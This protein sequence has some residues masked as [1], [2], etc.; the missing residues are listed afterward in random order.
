MG[1]K[2]QR[3]T[4]ERISRLSGARGLIGPG[5]SGVP[6]LID[7]KDGKITRIRPLHYE[8]SYDK[9]DFNA[10]KIEARGKDLRA[11]HE[12]RRR[13]HRPRVQEARLLEEP[14]ALSFEARRLGPQRRAEHAEQG[15]ERLCPHLVGRGRRTG[16]LRA[17][18]RG[19]RLTGP[20][21]SC[22]KPTCTARACT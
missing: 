10:W 16:R 17:E 12:R 18:A 20:R 11:P 14:R 8:M 19:Q 21:P 7:V 13:S 9:K 3:S 5:D 4:S 2:K 15:K 22:R 6:T 1:S